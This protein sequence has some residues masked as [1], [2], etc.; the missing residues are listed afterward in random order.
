MEG[1]TAGIRF[2]NCEMPYNPD[3]YMIMCDQCQDW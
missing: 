1:F 2:C 3:K